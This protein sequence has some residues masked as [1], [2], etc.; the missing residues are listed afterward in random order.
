[1]LGLWDI[2][3]GEL[4]RSYE[5]RELREINEYTSIL[6]VAFTQDGRKALSAGRALKE[7]SVLDL[8]TGKVVAKWPIG[9]FVIDISLAV[10]PDG[11]FA[12]SSSKLRST[13]LWDVKTGRALAAFHNQDDLTRKAVFSPDSQTVIIATRGPHVIRVLEVPT[14]RELRLW[15]SR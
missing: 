13:Q 1:M 6:A 7:I 9:G 14:L 10:S 15:T 8:D 12:L 11:R 5:D 3:R 2:D 4:L